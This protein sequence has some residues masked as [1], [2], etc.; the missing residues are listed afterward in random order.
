MESNHIPVLPFFA[1]LNK[2]SAF[3]FISQ[4]RLSIPCHAKNPC[5][6]T[7]SMNS[8]GWKMGHH[9]CVHLPVLGTATSAHPA[10]TG[11]TLKQEMAAAGTVVLHICWPSPTGCHLDEVT[12]AGDMASCLGLAAE[13][14]ADPTH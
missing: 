1:G 7:P 9:G 11:A 3:S 14:P 6:A 12:L 4:G 13:R 8:P 10:Y 5:C 2:P